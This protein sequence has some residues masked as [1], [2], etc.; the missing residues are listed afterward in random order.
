MA[1]SSCPMSTPSTSFRLVPWS[2]LGSAELRELSELAEH[3]EYAQ[4]FMGS[5]WFDQYVKAFGPER[6]HL[7]MVRVNDRTVAALPM[8]YCRETWMGRSITTLAAMTNRWTP[9]FELLFR[10]GQLASAVSII[11]R[12]IDLSGCPVVYLDRLPCDSI[13]LQA[14]QAALAQGRVR[15]HFDARN[16]SPYKDLPS[17]SAELLAGLG[18]KFRSNLRNRE[19]RLQKLGS[20]DFRVIDDRHD[21]PDALEEFFRLEQSGWK[22]TAGGAILSN[23]D[24]LRFYRGYCAHAGVNAAVAFLSVNGTVVAA[25]MFLMSS[26]TLFLLKTAYREDFSPYSPGQVIT[27]H[28]IEHAISHGIERFDFLGVAMD[29]KLDWGCRLHQNTCLYVFADSLTGKAAYWTRFGMRHQLKKIKPL[30]DLVRRLQS[31]HRS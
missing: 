28:L 5:E 2:Q 21:L 24:A 11:E 25:N 10:D 31:K 6:P 1:I 4:P 17:S 9:R 13:T 14:V 12:M 30:R 23:D 16:A 18:G 20:V 19:R 8:H 29:W 26:S 27:R 15:Y 22:G 7:F 3:S